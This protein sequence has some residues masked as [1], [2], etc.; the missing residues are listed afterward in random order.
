[1]N[2]EAEIIF[3]KALELPASE[4][5][6]FLAS[7][8]DG[9]PQLLAELTSLLDQSNDAERYFDSLQQSVLPSMAANAAIGRTIDHY[10]ILSHI[11]D[12]GM[13]T[14]YRALDTRLNREVALKFLPADASPQQDAAQRL[15]REARAAAALQHPNIC[16]I[17]D[18]GETNEGQPFIAMS[19]CDGGTLKEKLR[20]GP[21]PV[22]EAI[23]I[24]RQIA[25][26]LGAAHAR[27][28]VHRDVKP[29]NVILGTD[30]I[31]RLLDFGLAK[32]MDAA[33]TAPHGIRG[34]VAYMSPEQLRG[35]EIDER[36]DLWALGVMLFEML[37]GTRPFNDREGFAVIE[38]ILQ[39]QPQP[40]ANRNQDVPPELSRIVD[41]LLQKNPDDRYA[42]ATEVLTDL[43]TLDQPHEQARRKPTRIA[44]L[45][46]I[47]AVAATA[48]ALAGFLSRQQSGAVASDA[49]ATQRRLTQNIAAYELYLR[50]RD[51]A[52]FRSDSGPVRGIEYLD[53][54][55]ALD[56][57]FAAAYAAKTYLYWVL[58]RL[59]DPD[60]TQ[61]YLRLA[62]SAANR[63]IE[64]SPTLPEA[65]VGLGFA[66]TI[67]MSN[68]EEAEAAMRRAIELGSAPNAHEYLGKIL[69]WRG[70]IDESIRE[71]R[72]E[73]ENDPLSATASADLANTLCVAGRTAEGLA[74]LDRLKTLE[75]PLRRIP[76]YRGNCYAMGGKWK[77]AIA[78]FR[79]RRDTPNAEGMVGFALARSGD[80]ASAIQLKRDLETLWADKRSVALDIAM[81]SAGLGD[82]DEFF[83]WLNR[84]AAE[85]SMYGTI[86]F[87]FFSDMHADARFVDFRQKHHF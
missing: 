85:L 28:I 47:G 32:F 16:V 81:I 19:L 21:L 78:A 77:E 22:N 60:T 51:P 43:A 41:R 8:C 69:L 35:D 80:R 87:P 24:A 70:K 27:K 18:V 26:G 84:S 59:D 13:G 82:R 34:T 5:A 10:Q 76:G 66:K 63:S 12:G 75:P 3:E 79:E 44:G 25:R 71:T 1:M 33:T 68:L 14:V 29:A 37:A 67:A 17:H 73:L 54:A 74:I 61:K 72:I 50:G 30:G 11:G 86:M 49:Q 53:Q 55:I 31:V 56:S 9:N 4:R 83:R 23:D 46:I 40:L 64:L 62:D 57:T 42:R 38:S 52:L 45:Y 39:D 48:L 20:A 65:W 7:A 6:A 15:K 36:A 58:A 2:E